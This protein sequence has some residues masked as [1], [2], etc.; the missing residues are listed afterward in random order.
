[1]GSGCSPDLLVNKSMEGKNKSNELS[2][3]FI[4]G[5]YSEKLNKEL[6]EIDPRLSK[7]LGSPSILSAKKRIEAAQQNVLIINSQTETAVTAISNI[8]P[9][10]DNDKLELDA[11][12]G[13]SLSKLIN[14]GGALS[15]N[16]D[17]AKL[18]VE[19]S[20]LLYIQKVNIDLLEVI[21]S[22]QII[23]N[24]KKI[25]EIYNEQ[26]DV[27]NKNLPLIKTAEKA[28]IISKTDVLKLEQLKLGSEEKFLTAKSAADAANLVRKKYQLNETDDFFKL[29]LNRWREYEV[30]S[31]A[32]SFI[33]RDLIQTQID[34]MEKEIEMI[35][36]TYSANVSLTG[37]ASANVTDMDNSLGFVGLNITVP[38]KDGGRKEF[39]I[40][41]KIN[42]VE[43]LDQERKD[44]DLLIE[45]S[46]QA[47]N[48]YYTIHK[49]RSKLLTDQIENSKK[50][51]DDLE[52]KLRAGAASVIDLATEKMNYYNLRRQ[53]T[54]YEYQLLNEILNF[55]QLI[56]RQCDLTD[57]CGQINLSL[58]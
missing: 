1:M 20:K 46:M 32:F 19:I 42:Q 51:A 10:L 37:T 44:L 34:I 6:Q 7:I 47:L 25:E 27:Y 11:T 53:N 48:N 55:Y 12:A 15:A 33:N 43:A 41:E 8:G 22:E 57:F 16:V 4:Y 17:N 5:N 45:T 18:N 14:D 24:F 54:E 49:E 9:K 2:N 36:A 38:I 3:A 31:D 35:E 13:V 56:G 40:Q 23:L 39:Q 30:Q 21:K 29:N 58:S 26:L 50:I 52:L 28:N